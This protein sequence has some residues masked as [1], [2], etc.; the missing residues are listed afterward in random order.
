MP[1][2]GGEDKERGMEVLK[3]FVKETG[4]K[5]PVIEVITTATNLP[6]E[7]GRDYKDAFRSMGLRHYDTMH[8]DTEERAND[9]KYIERIEK[10]DGVFFSGGNQEKV[11]SILR[12]TEFHKVLMHRYENDDFIIAGTSAGAAAM[13]E[14][15][16]LGGSSEES[17]LKGELNLTTGLGFLNGLVVD[18]HFTE[19]G[20]FG[21]LIHAIT[22][23][24]SVMGIGFGEDTG[25]VITEGD[26]LEIVGSGL[27]II[28]DGQSIKRTNINEVREGE[29]LSI[30]GI[31][32]H[33]LCEGDR[34]SI[35]SRD[36]IYKGERAQSE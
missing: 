14:V 24:P 13:S 6:R 3:R 36:F 35:S 20:R 15:M 2:G 34:F 9:R 25:A 17:L 21:R 26:V 31:T 8:I 11:S 10:A 19:R 22:A 12:G 18:T 28:V 5:D 16:I 29:P 27:V 23:N 33:V 7:V 30:N 32:M 1:I 4:A